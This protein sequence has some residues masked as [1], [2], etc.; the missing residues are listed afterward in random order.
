MRE[1]RQRHLVSCRLSDSP[2][3]SFTSTKDL[4]LL[5][6]KY[7]HNTDAGIQD[8]YDPGTTGRGDLYLRNS[9][10]S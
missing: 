7:K 10:V 8:L 6:Q 2:A 1:G 4:A 9:S 5:V 3:L